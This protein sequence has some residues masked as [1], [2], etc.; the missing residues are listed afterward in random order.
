[1]T[2]NVLDKFVQRRCLRCV[3]TDMYVDQS[4]VRADVAVAS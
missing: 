4:D 1:M 2:C 3:T